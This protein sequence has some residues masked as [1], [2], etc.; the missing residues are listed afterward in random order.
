MEPS[1]PRPQLRVRPAT[2]AD[3]DAIA[4]IKFAAFGN[5]VMERLMYP[6][7]GSKEARANFAKE[8][9]PPPGEAAAAAAGPSAELLIMVAELRPQ[10]A[11][12]EPAIVAFA[13]WRLVKDPLPKEKWD[14]C[15]QV[16]DEELGEGASAAVFN[17]FF[18]GMH[19]MREKWMKGDPCLC[20]S[21][22]TAL[23][24]Q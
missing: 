5:E 17:K 20:E 2:P 7:G 23:L 11:G 18:G 21:H 8:L 13:K 22:A 16:T 15:R 1:I 12:E 14:T 9:F 19:N 10:Q 4:N 24:N 3:A 6:D